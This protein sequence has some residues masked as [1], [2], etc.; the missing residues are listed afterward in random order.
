MQPDPDRPPRPELPW[1]MWAGIAGALAT[2]AISVTGIMSSGSSTAAIGFI[3]VPFVAIAAAVPSAVWGLALGYIAAHLRGARR[4]VRAVLV[5][6]W[7]VALAVP[8]V[9]GWQVY[10]GLGLQRAVR[11]LRGMDAARLEAE[12]AGSSWN[13]NKY[14]LGALAQNPAASAGLLARIAARPDP[15]LLEAMGSMWDVMGEN[16]K[17][18]AVMR[19]VAG[20]ANTDL[21]TLEKLAGT[22]N[23]Y[24]LHDVLRNPRTPL[25]LLQPHLQSTHYLV[26]W[27]LALNPNTPPVA[28]ERLSR[29]ADYNTRLHLTWNPATPSP[30]LEGLAKD[31]NE[32]VARNAGQAL[33]R[34]R[35]VKPG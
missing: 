25:R 11:A 32:S 16:R 19:L 30:I 35:G 33:E 8:A 12:F 3:F 7:V 17:G 4:P 24:V 9:I 5:T 2:T 13:R 22:G 28:L 34:R 18:L 29:S 10:E 15:E 21:T 14:F 26:E 27:A 31:A 20:N 6:A 23:E 1:A